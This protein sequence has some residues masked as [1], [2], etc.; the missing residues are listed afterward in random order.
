MIVANAYEFLHSLLAAGTSIS[1]PAQPYVG[2]LPPLSQIALAASLVPYKFKSSSRETSRGSDAAFRYLQCLLFT[3]EGPTY[4]YVRQAFTF[5]IERTRRRPRGYRNATRS[6]SPDEDDDIDH[7][8]CEAANDKSLW[9]RADDFWHIVGWA[10]SCSAAYKKRWER[11]KLWLTVMLDFLE[12]DWDV[13]IKQSQHDEAGQEAVLQQSLIWQYVLGEGQSM[14]RTTRRRIA[15]SIFAIASTESLKDYPEIWEN[16]TRE[17]REPPNKKQKLGNVDFETGE[18][19]DYDSDEEMK[20]APAR[21]TRAIERKL[22]VTPP[23]GLPDINNG[24]LNLHDAIE[25]LGGS[26]AITLRQRLLALVSVNTNPRLPSAD[27][28]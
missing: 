1:T 6:L 24:S 9:Y 5:P 22:E 13:C 10:F 3:I 7:L 21:V 23:P 16:E 25:R 2:Y 19:A 27:S 11:W 8:Y 17:P 14:T 12:A 28:I 4:P 15:K 18:V 26:D 20:D